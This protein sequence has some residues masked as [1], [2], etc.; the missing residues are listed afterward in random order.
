[1]KI[2]N[3]RCRLD[4]RSTGWWAFALLLVAALEACAAGDAPV[5]IAEAARAQARIYRGAWFEVAVPEGF[6]TRPSLKSRT[7]EGYDSVEF[8][9]PDQNVSFYLFAPQWDGEASDIAL[10][11]HRETIVS[12]RRQSLPDGEMRWFTI[13]AKDGS[14][15]RSYQETTKQEGSVRTIV[16]IKYRDAVALERYRE[17]YDAFRRSLRLFA[18]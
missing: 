3:H 14:Y 1:M 17:A 11:P 8:V 13:A 6:L 9:A 10:D 5:G 12:E 18:D 16:G 4:G 2:L 15:Q 7:G